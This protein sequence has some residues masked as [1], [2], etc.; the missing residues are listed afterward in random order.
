MCPRPTPGRVWTSSSFN[1][2]SLMKKF[3]YHRWI[4][5]E[6]RKRTKNIC[7]LVAFIRNSFYN[8][9]GLE[10]GACTIVKTPNW[11]RFLLTSLIVELCLLHRWVCFTHR[12]GTMFS[13]LLEY[14]FKHFPQKWIWTCSQSLKMVCWV[15]IKY[16]SS[17]NIFHFWFHFWT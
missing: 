3:E 12:W 9:F 1:S 11:T 7:K 5:W 6:K 13:L 15:N 14:S 2:S 8:R 4:Y 16:F 17:L 10:K